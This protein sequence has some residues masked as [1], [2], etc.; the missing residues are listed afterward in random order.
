MQ[1]IP[2][3]PHNIPITGLSVYPMGTTKKATHKLHI[4]MSKKKMMV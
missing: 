2:N 4:M 3:T 1:L